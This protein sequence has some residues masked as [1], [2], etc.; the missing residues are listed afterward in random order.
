MLEF[1]NEVLMIED[2]EPDAY[3]MGISGKSGAKNKAPDGG[4]AG[5]KGDFNA[6]HPRYPKGHPQGGKFMPKGSKDQIK[7]IAKN[8]GQSVEKVAAAVGGKV[9]ANK[10]KLGKFSGSA[11]A[12][13]KAQKVLKNKESTPEQRAKAKASIAKAAGKMRGE[14]PA[15]AGKP[16]RGKISNKEIMARNAGKSAPVATG[17]MTQ[18]ASK[19]V[20]QQRAKR[21]EKL[22]GKAMGKESGKKIVM[23]VIKSDIARN[24]ETNK[25]QY[26]GN[27]KAIAKSIARNKAKVDPS[28]KSAR[29]AA[30]KA[31]APQRKLDAKMRKVG[32]TIRKV[33][34]K[35]SAGSVS[36]RKALD[37]FS[38]NSGAQ[39]TYGSTV[40]GGRDS[41]SYVT[42]SRKALTER[43][44]AIPRQKLGYRDPYDYT[45]TK[46]SIAR[47]AQKKAKRASKSKG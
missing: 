45:P 25:I 7:A 8:T 18:G 13:G 31:E 37:R 11:G 43:V 20:V 17:S 24:P 26:M 29:K 34:K 2:L 36:A 44:A 5:I 30:A 4:K 10:G 1:L 15:I 16:K 46:K 27:D 22:I 3:Q 41:A 21:R 33:E 39:S 38:S 32:Q 23:N 9:P 14:A 28:A 19:K 40:Y 42:N 6:M 47:N 35:A 12:V